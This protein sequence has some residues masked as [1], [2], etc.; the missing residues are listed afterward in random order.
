VALVFM[1]PIAAA[2]WI[3]VV[4]KPAVREA[5]LRVRSDVFR[6]IYETLGGLLVAALWGAFVGSLVMTTAALRRQR[7]IERLSEPL[8]EAATDS[9]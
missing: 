6:A 5:L 8:P 2:G 4:S 7:R 1:V 3:V 9:R